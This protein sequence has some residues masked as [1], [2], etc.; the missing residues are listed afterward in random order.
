MSYLTLDGLIRALQPVTTRVA[1]LISRGVV[2]RVDDAKK[3]Q[4]LQIDLLAGEV[5]DGIERLQQYGLTTVPDDDAEC[6][7]IF[8]GG[9]RDHGFAVAVDDRRYRPTGLQRGTV[10]LY[11]KAG[12]LVKLLPNGDIE[13]EP[14]SGKLKLTGDFEATGDVKAGAISLQNHTHNNL[15]LT[16]SGT[17]PSGTVTGTATGNTGGPS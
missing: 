16:V 4:E 7:V 6:V 8:V 3:V 9:R 14:A 2:K 12:S 10:C 11:D 15:S 5:R 17:S 13:L 1:N